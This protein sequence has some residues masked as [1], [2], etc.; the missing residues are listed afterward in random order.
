M[1]E[2]KNKTSLSHSCLE[3]IEKGEEVQE[4]EEQP[5]PDCQWDEKEEKEGRIKKKKARRKEDQVLTDKEEGK[6][7]SIASMRGREAEARDDVSSVKRE[8]KEV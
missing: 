4:S 6:K 1:R 8:E 2:E 5:F 3:S 7:K